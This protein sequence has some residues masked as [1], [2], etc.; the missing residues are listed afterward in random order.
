MSARHST[1]TK[2]TTAVPRT[3]DT[4]KIGGGGRILKYES[5]HCARPSNAASPVATSQPSYPSSGQSPLP[6]WPVC[7]SVLCDL[8]LIGCRASES[9]SVG[10]LVQKASQKRNSMFPGQPIKFAQFG[11][12]Q[13]PGSPFFSSH[14]AVLP[15]LLFSSTAHLDMKKFSCW[16]LLFLHVVFSSFLKSVNFTCSYLTIYWESIKHCGLQIIGFCTFPRHIIRS[17]L[18][19]DE[20]V[21]FAP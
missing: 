12:P 8:P 18:W 2:R 19:A 3:K 15:S 7:P 20:A 10:V 5:P 11:G 1:H 14:T 13:P 9:G 17:R 4:E 16:I 6:D 21:G